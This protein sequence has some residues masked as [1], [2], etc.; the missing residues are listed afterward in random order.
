M[1]PGIHGTPP[2]LQAHLRCW[3][4]HEVPKRG[5]HGAAVSSSALRRHA[6]L[7]CVSISA[8]GLRGRLRRRRGP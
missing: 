8:L 6:L 4:V 3:V 5:L 1:L 7:P 2:K